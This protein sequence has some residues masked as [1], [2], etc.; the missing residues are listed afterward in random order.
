M[1]LIYFVGIDFDNLWRQHI[2]TRWHKKVQ[3]MM[4][5]FHQDLEPDPHSVYIMQHFHDLLDICTCET[6]QKSGNYSANIHI[7]VALSL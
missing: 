6:S 1:L 4:N 7:H 5:V 2:S 3:T